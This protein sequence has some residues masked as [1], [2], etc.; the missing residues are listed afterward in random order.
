MKPFPFLTHIDDV[1]DIVQKY[2][3]FVIREVGPITIVTYTHLNEHLF[4][5]NEDTDILREC[6]GLIFCSKT[7]NLLSR[8]F[9]K[10][11][12]VDEHPRTKVEELDLDLGPIHLLEKVD[13][14]MLSALKIDGEWQWL[15]MGGFS[16]IAKTAGR[17]AATNPGYVGLLEELGPEYTAIFEYTSKDTQIVVEYPQNIT[18]L[19]IRRNDA[20]HYLTP[21]WI[22]TLAERHG[23]PHAEYLKTDIPLQTPRRDRQIEINRDFIKELMKQE[24]IEGYVMLTPTGEYVKV[25][26][27]WYIER[28]R[29]IFIRNE[30]DL[31]KAYYSGILDDLIPRMK[32][33]TQ[34]W[35]WH[36]ITLFNNRVHQIEQAIDAVVDDL[37]HLPP[38]EFASIASKS[39]HPGLMFAC[40]KNEDV[41]ERFH[42]L[43]IWHL[44]SKKLFDD[45]ARIY[46]AWDVCNDKFSW[47]FH[48]SLRRSGGVAGI[49]QV[50]VPE[51]MV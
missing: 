20:G 45:F 25:K 29:S 27:D 5:D 17:F 2:P 16:D 41:I 28:H 1:R 42:S 32:D 10:M 44:R 48:P 22:K 46:L 13:G 49:G 24:G 47:S 12:N 23:I 7:G 36:N 33:E 51:E 18:L 4:K 8:R 6:R 39:A 3:E 30:Y 38:K 9:H 31:M 15:T 50:H 37:R 34:E 14:S 11:F 19:G 35:C 43:V 40:Y 26:T 21:Y